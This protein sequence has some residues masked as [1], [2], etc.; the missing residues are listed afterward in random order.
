MRHNTERMI[1]F[2]HFFGLL[3]NARDGDVVKKPGLGFPDDN[4]ALMF[5]FHYC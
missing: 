5:A 3:I 1:W 4:R 2:C